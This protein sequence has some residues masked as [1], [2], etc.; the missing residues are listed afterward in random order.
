MFETH[1]TERHKPFRIHTQR[2]ACLTLYN[3][4]KINDSNCKYAIYYDAVYNI[5]DNLESF[6]F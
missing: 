6:K 1:Y 2:S 5:S 4:T 3:N